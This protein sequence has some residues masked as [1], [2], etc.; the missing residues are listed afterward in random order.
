M[1][2]ENPLTVADLD[3]VGALAP[4]LTL[5]M[6]KLFQQLCDG[7]QSH[8]L[9]AKWQQKY[10]AVTQRR[11]VEYAL[12]PHSPRTPALVFPAADA[13]WPPIGDAAGNPTEKYEVDYI[14]D[15]RGSEDAA[16]YLVKWRGIPEDQTTWEPAHHLT[17]CPA[18]LRAWRRL[19]RR[20]LQA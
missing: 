3:I 18:F 7:A 2:G 14:M 6:N 17:G 9:T 16:Q 10:Y 13:A 8:I 12:V 4:T 1:I 19:Q 5:P 15:Q 20:R 11:A